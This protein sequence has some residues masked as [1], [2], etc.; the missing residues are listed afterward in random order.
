[1]ALINLKNPFT[2]DATNRGMG[3]YTNFY[4]AFYSSFLVTAN[5][6]PINSMWLATLTNVPI[7]IINNYV[8]PKEGWK[9]LQ[10]TFIKS[11]AIINN[12][13]GLIIATGVKIVGDSVDIT[14]EGI[15]NTGY[16][17][18]IVGQGRT[19]FPL[20]NIAFVENNVSFVDYVLRPWQVAVSHESLKNQTL[21]TDIDI[22]FLA[23][24]GPKNPLAKRKAVRY[25]GCCPVNIDEQEYNYS[26]SDMYRIRTVQF[27][28]SHYSLIPTETT[29]LN[30]ISVSGATKGYFESLGDRLKDELERQL[31]VSFDRGIVSATE[32]Y[33]QNAIDQAANFGKDVLAGT[34]TGIVTNVA[35]TIQGAV[36]NA[37]N[38]AEG[39]V[40]GLG[41]GLT[42]EINDFTNRAI[43][44]TSSKDEI[45][46]PLLNA[47]KT[48][49]ASIDIIERNSTGTSFGHYVEKKINENDY[50]HY[51]KN[52]EQQTKGKPAEV[53]VNILTNSNDNI[54]NLQVNR[55]IEKRTS[56]ANA[57]TVMS[58]TKLKYN[59]VRPNA[60]INDVRNGEINHEDVVKKNNQ[61]DAITENALSSAEGLNVEEKS[62]NEDDTPMHKKTA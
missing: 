39:Y 26:G 53:N 48:T 12:T 49:G 62:I 41:T 58:N 23:K 6:L 51:A 3:Q 24:T 28:F 1:M 4:D 50:T 46:R 8:E 17:Q 21:K 45:S 27:A 9:G 22:I 61:A 36:D 5:A 47:D 13:K 29:L 40:A 60:S 19:G 30:L 33:I 34:A 54:S 52:I 59:L 25:Y 7:D 2:S 38:G 43:G 14:R 35:G 10:D 32:Q 56:D 31:G 16:I 57:D 55:S 18:G 44:N 20:L 15:K 37:I 11:K 42:D